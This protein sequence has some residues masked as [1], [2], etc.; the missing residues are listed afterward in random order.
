M[1]H[2]SV[3]EAQVQDDA[4]AFRT[5]E[6]VDHS[7]KIKGPKSQPSRQ[8]PTALSLDVDTHTLPLPN[9]AYNSMDSVH[10]DILDKQDPKFSLEPLRRNASTIYIL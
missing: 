10:P 2:T 7:R 3:A 6:G 5:D 9:V 8:D 1:P 4:R